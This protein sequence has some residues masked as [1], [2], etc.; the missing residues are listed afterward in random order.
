MEEKVQTEG[1]GHQAWPNLGNPKE[2]LVEDMQ[3]RKS[4]RKNEKDGRPTY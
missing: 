2:D 4:T 1:K 3:R